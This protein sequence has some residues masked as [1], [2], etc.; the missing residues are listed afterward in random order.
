[1]HLDGESVLWLGGP[2]LRRIL[3]VWSLHTPWTCTSARGG[4]G[5]LQTLRRLGGSRVTWEADCLRGRQSGG[6]SFLA[7]GGGP[8]PPAGRS[9]FTC[10]RPL[11]TR[12]VSWA[13]ATPQVLVLGSDWFQGGGLTVQSVSPVGPREA[14]GTIWE[15][16]ERAAEAGGDGSPAAVAGVPGV[17]VGPTPV[18]RAHVCFDQPQRLPAQ[19]VRGGGQPGEERGHPPHLPRAAPTSGC[20]S[21][22]AGVCTQLW[23]PDVLGATQGI[24]QGNIDSTRS[25]F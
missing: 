3:H 14:W 12:Q 20:T 23:G 11:G 19:T 6:P 9:S 21:Y 5:A 13:Q 18:P 17:P 4:R 22:S 16:E 10:A 24:F 25:T 8:E 2:E 15:G 1:M 7:S